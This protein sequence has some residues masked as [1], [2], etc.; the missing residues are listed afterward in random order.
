MG[1]F[2]LIVL[3]LVALSRSSLAS[4]ASF[5]SIKSEMSW[6]DKEISNSYDRIKLLKTIKGDLKKLSK[7]AKGGIAVDDSAMREITERA[8]G[9]GGSSGMTVRTLPNAGN[10]G[11]EEGMF[12]DYFITKGLVTPKASIQTTAKIETF[13]ALSFKP[14]GA[15]GPSGRQVRWRAG[16][17][18]QQHID[19]LKF[20][21]FRSSLRSS[22]APRC[23]QNAPRGLPTTSPP[24]RT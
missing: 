13:A 23:S 6:V 3:A 24:S 19:C 12:S 18:R 21:T 15:Q 9:G 5:E 17:K 11:G 4:P 14:K 8:G 7:V 22:F 16:A 2:H 1:F 20:T 10:V